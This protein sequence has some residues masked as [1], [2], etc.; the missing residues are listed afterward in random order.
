M[1]KTIFADLLEA[2]EAH[3]E[4]AIVL[5][6][7]AENERDPIKRAKLKARAADENARASIMASK[8]YKSASG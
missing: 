1:N 6:H 2:A 5:R 7:A 8:A 4:L 3:A